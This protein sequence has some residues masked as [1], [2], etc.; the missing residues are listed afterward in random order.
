MDASREFELPLRGLLRLPPGSRLACD[1]G[2]L[3]VTEDYQVH[4]RVLEP[5]QQFSPVGDGAVL[6]YALQPARLHLA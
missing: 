1:T 6:V 4:D 3:W 2:A 5:G